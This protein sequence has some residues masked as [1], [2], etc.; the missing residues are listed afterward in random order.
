V[1]T[2]YAEIVDFNGA[3]KYFARS[4]AAEWT[5]IAKIIGKLVPSFQ[6]SRQAGI[7]CSPIF[8]PKATNLALTQA[9]AKAGWHKVPVPA[10]L[11]ALGNDWDGGKN[12]TLAEWQFSNYPFLWNNIFR[13]EAVFEQGISLDGVAKVKA[14]LVLTKSGVFPLSNSSLYYEQAKAQ[15]QVVSK[16]HVF[17]VSMRLVGLGIPPGTRRFKGAWATYPGRTSRTAIRT[18]PC[19]IA[20]TLTGKSSKYGV[21]TAKFRRI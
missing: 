7:Q 11:R 8:D 14:L 5:E 2:V 19:R 6:P 16:L 4:G 20:V 1:S 3:T 13:T 9:A 12:G 18:T 15:L 10:K 21:P 17:H